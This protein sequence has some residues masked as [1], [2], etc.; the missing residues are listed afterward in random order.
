MDAIDQ[1]TMALYEQVRESPRHSP[2]IRRIESDDAPAVVGPVPRVVIMPG[3]F[4]EQYK[5]TGADGRRVID[6]ATELGW[7]V[8]TVPVPSLGS[9]AVNAQMLVRTLQRRRGEPVIL[10]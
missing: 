4:H 9:L 1:A 3:A 7:P 2:L 5:Q 8:E 10:V 6:L